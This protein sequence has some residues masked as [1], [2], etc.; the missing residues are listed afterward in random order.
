MSSPLIINCTHQRTSTLV[1]AQ[2]SVGVVGA[3]NIFAPERGTVDPEVVK[4]VMHEVRP[5]QM[6]RRF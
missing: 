2:S 6:L 3:D 4:I 5:T 1:D